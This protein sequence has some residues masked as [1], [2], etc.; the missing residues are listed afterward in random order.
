MSSVDFVEDRNF[1]GHH[2]SRA[3]E[4]RGSWATVKVARARTARRQKTDL[5]IMVEG[6]VSKNQGWMVFRM[7]K[8]FQV[9]KKATRE[10]EGFAPFYTIVKAM[11]TLIL[12]R[13]RA[14]GKYQCY[15]PQSGIP[16]KSS[17]T[18]RKEIIFIFEVADASA[19]HFGQLFRRYVGFSFLVTHS[20]VLSSI[21]RKWLIFPKFRFV[22]CSVH[23]ASKSKNCIRF[24]KRRS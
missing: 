18:R 10:E 13:K 8:M 9:L 2:F 3:A 5:E 19:G 21:T 11:V 6:Y 23:L 1:G 7:L 16:G 15:M 24:H 12:Q 4:L 17:I 14:T 22:S 20:C